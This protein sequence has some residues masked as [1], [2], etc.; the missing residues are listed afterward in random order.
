MRIVSS[1]NVLPLRRVNQ[2][3]V[4]CI[5]SFDISYI[6][7]YYS[8]DIQS[9]KCENIIHSQNLI[10]NNFIYNILFIYIIINK[11]VGYKR[12]NSIH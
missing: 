8:C 5:I 3:L 10:V 7:N 11:I 2:L 1:I 6:L 4:I 9:F 12:I